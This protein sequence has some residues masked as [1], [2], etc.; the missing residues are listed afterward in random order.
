MNSNVPET[1]EVVVELTLSPKEKTSKAELFKE[2]HG[3][4]LSMARAMR[5]AGLGEDVVIYRA[6]RLKRKKA[7]RKERQQK[8]GISVAY[9]RSG[10]KKAAQSSKKKSKSEEIV[11]N[12]A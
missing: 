1:Q 9:R 3:Y 5:R 7:L 4:S 10:G 11:K 12:V 8:R 2:V 6:L